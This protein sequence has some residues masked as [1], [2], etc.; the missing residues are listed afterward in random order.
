MRVH[1]ANTE[2]KGAGKPYEQSQA[3]TRARRD[4]PPKHNFRVE[5]KELITIPN[6]AAR[7]T[8]RWGP[9]RMLG[10]S[11]T[12]H[13]GTTHTIAWPWHTN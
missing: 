11:F 4:P 6:I 5:L 3:R 7:P 9:T 10:V 8:G 2:K 1:E 13:M 12:K